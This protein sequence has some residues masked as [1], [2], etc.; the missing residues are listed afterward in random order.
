M[1]EKYGSLVNQDH[2]SSP[3]TTNT[4]NRDADDKIKAEYDGLQDRCQKVFAGLRDLP[5]FG[6]W[7]SYYHRT[8]EIYSKVSL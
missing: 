5:H 4:L 3:S 1:D 2:S 7:D 6:N 8:F